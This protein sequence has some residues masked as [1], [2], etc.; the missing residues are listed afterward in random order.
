MTITG[1]STSIAAFVGAA[2]KGGVNRPARVTSFGD[3]EHRFGGLVAGMELGYAVR[4]FFSNGGA[5]ALVVRIAK[6]ASAAKVVKGIRALDGVDIFNLLAIPGITAPAIIAAAADYCRD[7]R[8]FLIV[9]PP[10]N[11]RTPSEMEA[12]LQSGALPQTSNAAVY[13]PWTKISD[14]M[15]HGQ[16]RS[17]PPSGT[18]AGLIARIDTTR[19]VWKSPAGPHANLIGVKTLEY[20]L[21]DHESAALNARGVNCLRMFPAFGQVAWGAR[22]LEGADELASDWKYVAVRRLALFLEESIHRG[23][24]WAEFEPNDEPLW[25]QLRLNIEAFMQSLFIQGAFQGSIPRDAFF[26]KCDARTTAAADI[27]NGIVNLEIGFAPLRPAEFVLI[28]IQQRA[29]LLPD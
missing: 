3:F 18:I 24:Q 5:E 28:R 16:P 25:A 26:V 21:T 29:G 27:V 2:K 19:G 13:Y 14:P 7:R 11:A 4:Q 10:V 22:T 23:T 20:N 8:A 12:F 9:D 6:G 15:H 1:V 17:V